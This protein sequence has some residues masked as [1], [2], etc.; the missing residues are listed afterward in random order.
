M[1]THP[2]EVNML[3]AENPFE[4]EG[5]WYKGNLHTH[6]TNSDGAWSIDKV[7][8][9]YKSGGYNFLFITDHGKVSDNSGL[10]A[11]NFLVLHGEELGAGKSDIGHSYHLVA[12]NLKETVSAEDAPDVQGL[13][14]LVRSKGGEVVVAHPYW[15]GLTINDLM[16]LEGCLGIEVF[17]TTCFTHIAKGHSAVHWDDMLARGKQA[18]GFAVDDTH[19]GTSEY[20]PIDICRAWIMAKLPELTETAVMDAIKAGKFYASNG[21]SIHDIS[22]KDGT[23]SV[24]TSEVKRIN[25]IANVSSGA[26]RAV[27]SDKFLTEAEYE[28]RGTEKY[29]R[30]ECFDKDGGCAWSN[31]V[32]I[33]E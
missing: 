30:V 28:I 1:I 3:L 19:Q 21:P 4:A 2:E 13:I 31:P 12:L 10:S 27:M 22:V 11:D 6:T 15:S 29:I 23:I 16:G 24:S 5:K 32:V 9:E 7:T 8:G 25:F 20:F 26:S 18:W 33:N 14:D 17:N